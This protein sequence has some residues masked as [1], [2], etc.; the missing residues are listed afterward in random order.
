MS[1]LMSRPAAWLI[2]QLA[3]FWPVWRWYAARV[4]DGSDDGGW[5][6]LALGTAVAFLWRRRPEASAAVP[7]P[8]LVTTVM[9]AYA[10]TYVFLPPLLRAALAMTAVGCA[11]SA[12][13]L[14]TVCHAGTWGLLM[15]SLPVLPTMQFYLGYP[16]RVAAGAVTV[17]LLQLG[18]LAVVR[19]GTCLNWGG[20][21]ISIDAPCSGVRMLWTGL[22][23]AFSLACLCRLGLRRTGGV[24]LVALAAVVLGNILRSAALFFVE[25]GI[26]AVPPWVHQGVGVAA[27]LAAA[28]LVAAFA[29]RKAGRRPCPDVPST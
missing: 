13:R 25:A 26:V 1:N 27:F 23:L 3:A 20:R 7:S 2:L 10:M 12:W 9:L 29:L 18:G 5:G 19:E 28:G 21:L 11:L 6:A 17:P 16:L 24:A 4:T 14:G 8:G 22:Y 15:L